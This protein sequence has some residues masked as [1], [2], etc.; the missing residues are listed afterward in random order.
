MDKI[1]DER[2]RRIALLKA[3]TQ[4]D[5]QGYFALLWDLPA[6]RAERMIDCTFRLTWR[7]TCRMGREGWCQALDGMHATELARLWLDAEGLWPDA[8]EA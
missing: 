8:D 6:D 4:R 1:T 5:A 7:M 2:L 3:I